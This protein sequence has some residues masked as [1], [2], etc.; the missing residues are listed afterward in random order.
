TPHRLVDAAFVE[1]PR[2]LR[3]ALAQLIGASEDD[4]ILGNSASYG[5][6]VLARGVHWRTG[7]EVLFV[8]GEF[9]ATVFPWRPLERRGVVLRFLATRAGGGAPAPEELAE[10]LTVR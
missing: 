5:L 8:D 7:D 1:V 2:R 3:A 10:A 6:D 4:V 9:P